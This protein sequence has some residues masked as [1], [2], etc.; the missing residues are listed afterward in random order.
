[1]I[2]KTV[3]AALAL[4]A[5]GGKRVCGTRPGRA[6]TTCRPIRSACD[7]TPGDGGGR[8]YDGGAA[9]QRTRSRRARRSPLSIFRS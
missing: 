8:A 7:A 6:A 2:R 3:I 9:D 5:H 4:A 1:M